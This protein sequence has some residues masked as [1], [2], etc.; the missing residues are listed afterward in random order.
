MVRILSATDSPAGTGFLVRGRTGTVWIITCSHVVQNAASQSRGDVLPTLVKFCFADGGDIVSAKVDPSYW[1]PASEDDIAVLLFEAELPVGITVIPLGSDAGLKNSL[2]ESRGYRLTSDFD[3]GL[4]ATGTIQGYISYRGHAMLQLASEQIDHG[5][6]GAPVWDT[7]RQRVVGVVNSFWGGD[8]QQDRQLAFATGSS[9]LQALQPDLDISDICPYRGLLS[10]T[11]SESAFFYGR[12]QLVDSL[13]AGLRRNGRFLAV[14]GSSGSGKSSLVQAGLLPALRNGVLSGFEGCQIIVFRPRNAPRLNL[15]HAIGA[16]PVTDGIVFDEAFGRFVAKSPGSRV[17]LFVDQ[18]EELF[19]LVTAQ[20]STDLL[21]DLSHLVESRAVTLI[22][23][24]RADFYDQFLRSPLGVCTELEQRHVRLM[25]DGELKSAITEPAEQV[26]LQVEGGLTELIIRDLNG[27][28]NTLPLLEFTLTELWKRRKD[29][30]LRIESY[31]NIGGALGALAQWA[32]EVYGS[33]SDGDKPVAQRIFARLIHYGEQGVPDTRRRLYISEIPGY[34]DNCILPDV[35]RTFATAHLLVTDRDAETGESTIEL[36]HDALLT[37]WPMLDGWTRER[38]G[39]LVWR[40]RLR[41]RLQEHKA[42]SLDSDFLLR[43][44]RLAEGADWLS[45]YPSELNL[46]ETLYISDSVHRD[47]A[48]RFRYWLSWAA[49]GSVIFLG[50]LGYIAVQRRAIARNDQLR[51]SNLG[52]YRVLLPH[53]AALM[54][55]RPLPKGSGTSPWGPGDPLKLDL[56]RTGS[57]S[58]GLAP[59][60]YALEYKVRNKTYFYGIYSRGFGYDPTIEPPMPPDEIPGYQFVPG[61]FVP[62]G[63][64]LG[65]GA[66]GESSTGPVML[67]PYFIAL[68]DV[69]QLQIQPNGE[70]ALAPVTLT[71]QNAREAARLSGARLPTLVEWEWAATLGLI[72]RQDQPRWEWTSTRSMKGPYD[73]DDGRNNL[74]ALDSNRVS[75][76]GGLSQEQ[77]QSDVDNIASDFLD[78]QPAIANDFKKDG[79]NAGLQYEDDPQYLH[80]H[81]A[82]ADFLKTHPDAH[83]TVFQASTPS[84]YLVAHP[85]SSKAEPITHVHMFRLARG[86]A[87][88]PKGSLSNFSVNFAPQSWD[89]DTESMIRLRRFAELWMTDR[90]Q[91]KEIILGGH[92]DELGS[93][94]YDLALGE[95]YANSVKQ[96]LAN[97]GVPPTDMRVITYGK[98]QPSLN[99]FITRSFY[100]FPKDDRVDLNVK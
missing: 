92:T 60:Y 35:V 75:V 94:E 12:Q 73:D 58:F 91:G 80:D 42:H 34:T 8:R 17:V 79:A 89:P 63:D 45:K 20:E 62:S 49:I 56:I 37:E 47:K 5:M 86:L 3:L 26:G 74:W 100:L 68:G 19:T 27:T 50:L 99:P 83:E 39:F 96:I 41:E 30:E 29:N 40:Q 93:A 32:D 87:E 69:S 25:T 78:H 95:N 53:T 66:E 76:G 97:E 57:M 46:D 31:N 18:L 2:F 48:A 24:L 13:L 15:F 72:S 36:V 85:T 14:I 16:D 44:S 6:S 67:R 55:I 71:W 59:G 88:E 52:N 7:K 84:K 61:G 90:P 22:V 11:E 28:Q 1:S 33:L 77:A 51:L 38:R 43:G 54:S 82:L 65:I 98:E 23:A 81:P 9:V 64:L 21:L 70:V 10:F 4:D